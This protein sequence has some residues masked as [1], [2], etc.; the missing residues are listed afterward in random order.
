MTDGDIYQ[1]MLPVFDLLY[2]TQGGSQ[3]SMISEAPL[4]TVET[5]I[6]KVINNGTLE[7]PQDKM[8]ALEQSSF[9]QEQLKR[10]LLIEPPNTN[11]TAASLRLLSIKILNTST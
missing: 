6:L 1:A 9:A 8:N 3:K 11:N 7:I 2:L 10:S 4:N 5:A